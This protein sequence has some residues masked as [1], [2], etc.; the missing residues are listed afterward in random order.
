MKAKSVKGYLKACLLI[1]HTDR[2][3]LKGISKL[4]TEEYM[5][6]GEIRAGVQNELGENEKLLEKYKLKYHSSGLDF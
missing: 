3:D 5:K 1:T 6:L 4:T 2:D